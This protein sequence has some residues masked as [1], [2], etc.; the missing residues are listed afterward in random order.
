MTMKRRAMRMIRPAVALAAALT[1]TVAAA[2]C[3][4]WGGNGSGKQ[5]SSATPAAA[6]A[7]HGGNVTM[8]WVGG[9]PN[10]IFPL[11]PATNTDGYNVNLQEPMWPYLVY[12]GNRG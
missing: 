5:G 2:A 3:S 9:Y 12:S 8:Q 10:F 1:L 7:S 11:M 6:A 4:S